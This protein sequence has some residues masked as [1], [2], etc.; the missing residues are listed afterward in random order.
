M[1]VPIIKVSPQF[2]KWFLP[3]WVSGITLFPF[4]LIKNKKDLQDYKLLNHESIHIRQQLETLIIIFY[5]W[6][7]IEYLIRWILT[8]SRME[9]YKNISF[10]REA[11][12]NQHDKDYIKNRPLWAH[13]NWLRI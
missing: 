9:A 5:L 10:E 4:I 8:D 7:G 2:F 13:L 11:Y 3:Q 12:A 6:Y 1:S